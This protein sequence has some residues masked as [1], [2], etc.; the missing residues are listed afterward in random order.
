MNRIKTN[1]GNCTRRL[2][3]I[4]CRYGK[5]LQKRW[6][7]ICGGVYECPL[8]GGALS[9]IGSTERTE[10]TATRKLSRAM[11]VSWI[12]RQSARPAM[13][14]NPPRNPV[15]NCSEI[16]QRAQGKS[17][18]P[19]LPVREKLGPKPQERDDTAVGRQSLRLLP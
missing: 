15:L 14:T 1:W 6:V 11:F 16:G 17:G 3:G 13:A 8:K 10:N 12:R 2:R 7:R 19:G 9:A 18:A 5:N 4:A